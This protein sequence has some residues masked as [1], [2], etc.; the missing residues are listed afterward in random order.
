MPTLPSRFGPPL[1]P[2]ASSL[3]G[4]RGS[5]WDVA[6]DASGIGVAAALA[7]AR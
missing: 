7:L 1:A 4:R 5:P 2:M 6:I 3:E